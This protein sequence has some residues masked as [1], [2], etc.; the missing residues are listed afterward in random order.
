[1]IDV[2]SRLWTPLSHLALSNQ[3]LKRL[4]LRERE[5]Q[6]TGRSVVQFDALAPNWG[7]HDSQSNAGG[8]GG[9]GLSGWRAIDAL[10]V[11]GVGVMDNLLDVAFPG[12]TQGPNRNL[13]QPP[14][15]RRMGP[16][17]AKGVSFVGVMREYW[18]NERSSSVY[19]PS[20]QNHR[21]Y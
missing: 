20:R 12:A 1:M 13:E 9:S 21:S 6:C 5:L 3:M 4:S 10:C 8:V 14:D 15:S 19:P 11:L 17:G 18:R 7:K 16:S 2:H